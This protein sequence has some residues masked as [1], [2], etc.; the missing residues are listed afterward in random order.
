[1]ADKIQNEGFSEAMF[2]HWPLD[3]AI[4]W[5]DENLAPEEVFVSQDQKLYDWAR[6]NAANALSPQDVFTDIQLREWALD[7]GFIEEENR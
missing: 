4:D 2:S 1:M 6:A 5:M 3:K 7:N